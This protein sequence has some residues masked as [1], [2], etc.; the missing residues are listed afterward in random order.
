M[1][2]R[3]GWSDSRWSS[4][5]MIM[6]HASQLAVPLALAL[7]LATA[8]S[9]SVVIPAHGSV[10]DGN[11]RFGLATDTYGFRW[12]ILVDAA[13][14]ASNGAVLSGIAFR[15]DEQEPW[16][17][18]A[19]TNVTVTMSHSPAPAAGMSTSFANNIA[20]PAT[21]V[22]QGSVSFP[23]TSAALAGP[24]PWDVVVSF[25]VPYSFTSAQGNLLIDIV[26]PGLTGSATAPIGYFLDS[27]CGGGS[28][29]RFGV[30]GT[31]ASTIYRPRLVC[32]APSRALTTGNTITFTSQW[33]TY[34]FV[35][36][37]T[38]WI[39]LSL[40]AQPV[41]IDLGPLGAPA[42]FLYVDPLVLAS[43]PWTMPV[44]LWGW[45]GGASVTVPNN[46]LLVGTMLYAQSAGFDPA[47]NSLGL[48][49]GNA[50]E[51]RIGDASEQ[52]PMRML[53]G[54]FAAASGSFLPCAGPTLPDYGAVALRL[55]GSFF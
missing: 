20:G 34:P 51:V 43:H 44:P 21:T 37:G 50:V 2:G 30:S 3:V 17:G 27:V 11:G 24:S 31:S 29:T 40:A 48:V 49:T 33:G 16:P 39:A 14:I 15:S 35:P 1:A 18:A 25:A 36:S 10:A 41:P 13:A 23:G 46:P 52:L 8:S 5:A 38:G 47:A 32:A 7:L 12:Q 26:K 42:N 6:C 53:V 22:F 9:Q 28:A 54:S 19:L 55:D 4:V 45:V